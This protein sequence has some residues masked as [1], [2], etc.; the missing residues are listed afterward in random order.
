[1]QKN[2]RNIFCPVSSTKTSD[3][4]GCGKC[5]EMEGTFPAMFWKLAAVST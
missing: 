4:Q 3:P 5:L 1:M 2:V